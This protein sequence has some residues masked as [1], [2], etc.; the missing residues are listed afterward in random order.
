VLFPRMGEGRRE[1][2]GD[3]DSE[4][5]MSV[6]K[7]KPRMIT[8]SVFSG[9]FALLFFFWLWKGLNSGLQHLLGRYSTI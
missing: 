8:P 1:H 3:P 6:T 4:C 7:P 9:L 5:V 2:C